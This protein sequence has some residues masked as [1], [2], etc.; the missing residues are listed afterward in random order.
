MTVSAVTRLRSGVTRRANAGAGSYA[1]TQL[2]EA[3]IHVRVCAGAR[4]RVCV[5][6]CEGG[7]VTA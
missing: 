3:P 4:M 6:V 5:C 7:C 1:V 2:R